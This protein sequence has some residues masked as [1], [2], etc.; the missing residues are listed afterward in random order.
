MKYIQ[1]QLNEWDK[2]QNEFLFRVCAIHP[3]SVFT[4]VSVIVSFVLFLFCLPTCICVCLQVQGP[5]LECP[6]AGRLRLPSYWHHLCMFLL[7]V[8]LEGWLSDS[9]TTTTTKKIMMGR[10]SLYECKSKKPWCSKMVRKWV[11]AACICATVDCNGEGANDLAE[12]TTWG[13]SPALIL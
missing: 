8:H 3:C 7:P 1:K 10:L 4:D 2:M 11:W 13:G 9:I 12:I 5:F 6:R